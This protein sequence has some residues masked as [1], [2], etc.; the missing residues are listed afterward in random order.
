MFLVQF[1]VQLWMYATPII[2]PL[3]TI[4]EKYRWIVAANPMTAIVETFK[5]GFL[6]QQPLYTGYLLYS[7]VF[8]LFILTLGILV[9]NKV[10]KGFMD[11]I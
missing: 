4:P 2:Y 9:F 7:A 3:S 5:F 10:E 8:T 6:D 1:G 11:T